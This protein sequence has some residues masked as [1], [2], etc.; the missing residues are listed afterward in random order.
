LAGSEGLRFDRLERFRRKL[1]A[2]N[3]LPFGMLGGQ[4]VFSWSPAV[5]AAVTI[6]AWL[7]IFF[8]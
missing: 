8:L 3:L 4:K 7:M 5:W 2:F 1:V 6:P